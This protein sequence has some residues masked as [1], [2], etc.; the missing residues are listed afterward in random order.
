MS[1][2]ADFNNNPGNLKPQGFTYKGQI[3]IDDQGFAVFATKE[4]GRNALIQDIQ[5]KQRDG[6]NT[7]HS[8]IN[9]YAPAGKENKEEGRDNYKIGMAGHLGLKDTNAPFPEGS[10]EKI[11]DFITSFESGTQ[12]SQTQKDL[13][14]ADPNNPFAAGVPLADK[15]RQP[16]ATQ[17]TEPPP[18]PKTFQEK[19]ERFIE[20][21]DPMYGAGAGALI[22]M[23]G[24]KLV[25][26]PLTPTELAS[27]SAQDK[28][29]LTRR[30]LQEIVPQGAE[31][32]QETYA[33]S[34]GEVE[35]IKNEQRLLEMQ[36]KSIP[37]ASPPPAPTP[38]EQLKIEARKIA[39]AGAPYNTVQA[40]ASERVPY[41]LASQAIDMTHGEGHGKGAHDIVDVFNQGKQKA[42]NLGMSDFVLAGEKGP[43]ELYL[44]ND[45]A[46]PKNAEIQQRVDANQ[47]QQ[48]IFEQQQEQE[49]LR[50]QAE[51]DRI[52]QERAT[53]GTRQNVL[54]GQMS[55]VKPLQR[56]M[57]KLEIDAEA[58]RLKA[59]RAK[60][61][62]NITAQDVLNKGKAV[63]RPVA[64]GLAGYYG[65]MSAQQALE[66][67]KAGDRSEAVMQALGAL[68]ATASLVPPVG[69]TLS[70][71]KKAG[72]L[73]AVGMAG[74]EIYN[75]LTKE[76]PPQ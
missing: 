5:I 12:L 16:E 8:F 36:L 34:K 6:F 47:N 37:P 50:L 29:D 19:T 55:D 59:A 35:R 63:G 17:I 10:A 54:A 30:K 43:G 23:A 66:R 28:L 48:A 41:S 51:L 26:P 56:S 49:R 20:E 75:R 31:N 14:E 73:G 27:A 57:T 3:G 74:R 69:K 32:L 22:N 25:K 18:P 13:K 1:T 4:A 58:A 71:V 61:N 60:Q 72:A 15:A 33:Q 76:N 2:I 45:L 65:V 64:G 67:Y 11:A 53:Q 46:D 39:G 42:A 7:P 9:K 70:G 44:P 40:F 68:S 52:R 21:A 62:P 38:Q 24:S